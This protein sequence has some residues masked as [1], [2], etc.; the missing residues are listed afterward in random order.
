LP[1]NQFPSLVKFP[2][3]GF[4]ERFTWACADRSPQPRQIN[5]APA[6][7]IGKWSAGRVLRWERMASHLPT[8]VTQG[9]KIIG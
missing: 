6:R 1:L 3:E 9:N 5:T 8:C 7:K 4:Q 2:L